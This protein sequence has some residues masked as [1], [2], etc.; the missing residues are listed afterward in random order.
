MTDAQ[1]KLHATIDSITS[2]VA[3][4][5]GVQARKRDLA[6]GDPRATAL[7]REAVAIAGRLVPKTV[8]ERAL[9]E[10]MAGD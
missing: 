8:T 2:D 3:D 1:R 6:P 9:V 10:D 5:K 4:L 7:A